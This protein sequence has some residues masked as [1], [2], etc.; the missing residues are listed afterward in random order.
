MDIVIDDDYKGGDEGDGTDV[1]KRGRGGTESGG[2]SAATTPREPPKG[3]TWAQ[4]PEDQKCC[5]KH[6]WMKCPNPE[7]CQYGPHLAKPG[8]QVMR[9]QLYQAM[10]DEHGPPTI[11]A[12][13]QAAVSAEAQK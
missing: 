1:S 9:H 12:S 4:I 13:H 6:F 8:P 2:A 5:I 11:T 7:T 10:F 3:L